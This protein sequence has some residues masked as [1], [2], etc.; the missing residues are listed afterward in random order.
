MHNCH[1]IV[2]TLI[3]M[4]TFLPSCASPAAAPTVTNNAAFPMTLTDQSGRTV[5]I[6]RAP[7]KI[8]SLAPSN[9]EIVYALG[10]ADNLA[11]VTE[12]CNYPASALSKPKIGGF[13]TVNIEKVVAI[14]P[15]LI[16]AADVHR[17]EIVPELERLGLTVITI[18]PHTID[19]VIAAIELVGKATERTDAAVKLAAEMQQRIKAVTGRTAALSDAQ[20]PRVFYIVW[21]NPLMT[22]GGMTRINE[23]IMMAGGSSISRNLNEDY[24]KIS[25]EVVINTNPEIIISGGGHG[26]G[27]SEPLKYA[28]AEPRLAGT[29]ARQ[30]QHVYDIDA[31]LTSRPGPRIVDGL[32]ALAEMIHPEMFPATESTNVPRK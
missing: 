26:T 16:I 9:T 4:F 11:G 6:E 5:T 18:D 17:E 28:L 15:D 7:Q 3:S 12:Y 10:L 30:N 23:L 20:R 14:Q 22:T 32:E 27:A 29:S 8:V 2:I 24:P 25:L 1:L 19:E 31:D 21:H 13:S